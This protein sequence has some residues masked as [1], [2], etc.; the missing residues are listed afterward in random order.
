M[1]AARAC[2]PPW[3]PQATVEKMV[4]RADVECELA[5]EELDRLATQGFEAIRGALMPLVDRYEAWIKE[6]AAVAGLNAQQ[7]ATATQLLANARGQAERI[8]RGIEALAEPDIRDAFAIANRTMAAAAR[9]RYGVMQGLKGN[10]PSLRPPAWRPFQLAFLL[11]HLIGIAR[12]NDPQLDPRRERDNVDLLFFPTGGGKTEA[13][14]NRVNGVIG[15]DLLDRLAATDRFHGDLG[16][17][18]GTVG[19]AFG[20]GWGPFSGVVPRL[21]G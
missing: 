19:T 15:C 16:L 14:L 17:E 13:Y 3:I 7:Q 18:L 12:P 11:M 8:A 10:D 21:R 1:A 6:Q 4:P 2:A 5:M 20:H 9:Q